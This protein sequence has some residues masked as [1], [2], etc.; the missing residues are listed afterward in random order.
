M[1]DL[2][3]LQRSG[4]HRRP[5]RTVEHAGD[6]RFELL[7]CRMSMT[8]T[9][10]VQ[11]KCNHESTKTRRAD[12]RQQSSTRTRWERTESHEVA[13]ERP[14]CRGSSDQKETKH[15]RLERILRLFLRRSPLRAVA[16]T[17]TTAG[18]CLLRVIR[19]IRSSVSPRFASYS[20]NVHL[21]HD[22]ER[23]GGIDNLSRDGSGCH[24]A[25]PGV[26]DDH[27]EGHS[28]RRLPVRRK[29]DKPRV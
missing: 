5:R 12:V 19:F 18:I 25:V 8:V 1:N 2:Q 16:H 23:H 27:G 24:A 26:L 15:K 17:A 14:A 21:F 29:T 4:F 28:L 11:M 10:N 3:R 13:S 20:R 7:R 9:K 22:A 6:S